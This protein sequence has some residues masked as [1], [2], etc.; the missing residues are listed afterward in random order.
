M[1]KVIFWD[2]QGNSLFLD[3]ENVQTHKLNETKALA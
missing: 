2:I 1:A 3:E